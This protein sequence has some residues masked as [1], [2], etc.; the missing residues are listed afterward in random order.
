M[1]NTII[2][3]DTLICWHD[4]V[5]IRKMVGSIGIEGWGGCETDK[6]SRKVINENTM[7]YQ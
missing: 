2:N 3:Y 4:V 6:Q 1:L 5:G 7:H